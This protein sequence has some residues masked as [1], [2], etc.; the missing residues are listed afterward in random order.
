M[1]TDKGMVLASQSLEILRQQCIILPAIT[2]IKRVCAEAVTRANRRI[3]RELF[4]PLESSFGFS[5]M[6]TSQP[7][8]RRQRA[9]RQRLSRTI[10][11]AADAIT[12]GANENARRDRAL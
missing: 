7:D 10:G 5:R 12:A 1:Q 9:G 8:G 3:Y 4:S 6:K 11:L 2:V